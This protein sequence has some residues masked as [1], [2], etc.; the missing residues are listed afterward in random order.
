MK[1][2]AV[3]S[4]GRTPALI[5]IRYL[6]TA[7]TLL[8]A[9]SL[10]AEILSA[11]IAAPPPAES[12]YFRLG[13]TKNP[14]GQELSANN[15]S[16]LLNGQPWFPVMGEIHYSR[17]P[18]A[19]WR[20]ALL[21]M[22]AG[23]ITIVATYVFWIHH[24]EVRGQWDWIGQRDLRKFLQT[25][26]EVGLLAVV[27]LG[28]WC[29]GEVRNGGFPDWVQNSGW[30][31]RSNDTNYLAAA[32]T[33]YGEI[34]GQL[35]GQLWK[36][37]GPVIGV[38]VEN[39]FRGSPDH[40]MKLKRMAI[41]AGIDVPF[42][43]KTGW[44]AMK[45]PVPLGELFPLFGAYADG[46]WERGTQPMPGN[47]WTKFTFSTTRTDTGVANDTL[48]NRKSGD[49]AGTDK[50]PYLTCEIGG[51]MPASYHRRMNYDPRDVTAVVLCQLG[52]G[53]SLMG[54]YMYHGGQNPEGKLSTLQESTATGYPNDLPVK[55]YDF[56]API[57]EFGQ[58]NPHYYWLRRLHL[59]LH[60]F[61]ARL[62]QMPTTL[63]DVIPANKV[64]THTL[65]WCVR[66]D[67]DAGYVFVNNYERLRPLPAKTNVQFK[68]NLP[69][70]EFI[71]PRQPVTIPADAFFIWPFKLHMDCEVELDYA[72]AQPL[73][74]AIGE[75]GKRTW[76]F[77][78]TEGVPAEFC[79]LRD[80]LA[81]KTSSGTIRREDRRTVVTN[82][83]SG[84]KPAILITQNYGPS[85]EIVLLNE[86]DSLAL[87]KSDGK[88]VFDEPLKFKTKTVPAEPLKSAG[89]ARQVPMTT[90][91]SP[92]AIAPTD[93]DFASAAV[94][95]IQLPAKLD[96]SG[97]PLLRIH[98]VGDVARLTLN[99]KL[100]ADNFYAGR[101]FDLGLSRYAP[102]ILT[103]D[104]R[105][106]I[107]PLRRDAPIFIEP[108]H[109]PTFGTNETVLTL[110]SVE[111]ITPTQ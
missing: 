84:R 31:L 45:S 85:V 16:L 62:S 14:V 82:L 5:W 64:D 66:S 38:Q 17:V 100:I 21:K 2:L 12:G 96:L 56:N 74:M 9:I 44:P 67:G 111:V 93:A 83:S 99:G 1:I 106:E 108:Q 71:F 103:G 92:V 88:V 8:L 89:P 51:G 110:K 80:E 10:R 105:L 79:F 28:P 20:D 36:D 68:L 90:G 55:S 98:Y 24:E 37:G 73:G 102:E 43:I 52:G 104:L 39:E 75:G 26:H 48:G 65:R 18:Q 91:K 33:L 23:G 54:Y 11:T 47:S 29:H 69:G 87:H 50:Y 19:E 35:R 86:A 78:A 76:Y 25:C 3:A 94:W 57:G 4:G 63:P 60:D 61:G 59:F 13:T 6:A 101:E 34:A 32:E 107:L 49:T 46:F 70:G 7:F 58:I 30:K 27:R 109:K 42:Y 22:K 77:A 53:G 15:R 41:S 97:N 81:V 40:L 72:T 95:R